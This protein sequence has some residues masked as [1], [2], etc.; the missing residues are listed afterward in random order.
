M[1]DPRLFEGIWV[2]IEAEMDGEKAPQEFVE[3]AE[4]E[5]AGG[6][7][8]VR[9]GGVAADHGTYYFE[10][11][12]LTL[13][14]MQGP[15]AGKTIPCLHRFEGGILVVCYGLGGSRPDRFGTATGSQTYLARY[16]RKVK[17]P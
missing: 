6:N 8:T 12:G 2:P 7:Y 11:A 9:F 5:L 1:D 16:R 17:T 3:Y 10:P 15:N 13:A 4:V 14:G